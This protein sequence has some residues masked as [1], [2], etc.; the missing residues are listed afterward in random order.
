MQWSVLAMA[1]TIGMYASFDDWGG[2]ETYGPR[3][4]I[5]LLPYLIVGLC[6]FFDDLAK[7]P[8][9]KLFAAS[10]AVVIFASVFVQVVGVFYYPD[11]YSPREEWYDTWTSYNPWDASDSVIIN[12]LFHKSATPVLRND[13]DTWLNES[14][15]EMCRTPGVILLFQ[16]DPER[17]QHFC[18]KAAT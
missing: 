10:I 14:W 9:N 2:G 3:Y 11:H 16:N 17:Y 4:L 8:L 1:V 12:S 15:N 13:N 7:K 18:D 6:I 5:C